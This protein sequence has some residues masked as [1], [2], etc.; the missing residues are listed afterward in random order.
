MPFTVEWAGPLDHGNDRND[1]P[2][3][4]PLPLPQAVTSKDLARRVSCSSGACKSYQ[5][6]PY[7]IRDDL[8]GARGRSAFQIELT[9][10][11]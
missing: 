10:G 8:S 3:R 7:E 1:H 9:A 5:R 4:L 6:S 2:S 11:D